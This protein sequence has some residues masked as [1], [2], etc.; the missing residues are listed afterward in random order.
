MIGELVKPFQSAFILGRQLVHIAV[1]V[2]EIIP[3]WGRKGT[4]L[5]FMLMVYLSKTYDSLD[6]DFQ[7][8]SMR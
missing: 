8:S 4:G 3:A 5:G 7:W 6:K 1:L 2:G